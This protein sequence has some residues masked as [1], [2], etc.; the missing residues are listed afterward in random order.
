MR[1]IFAGSGQI[2]VPT[3]LALA[4]TREDEFLGVISQPDK[5]AGRSQRLQPCPVRAAVPDGVRVWQPRSIHDPEFV[6]ELEGLM[7]DL[8]VVFAYGQILKPSLLS[9]PRIGCINLHGSLLPR[10]RGAA[11]LQAPILNGDAETGWTVIWMDAGMDTGD[12]LLQT[13]EPILARETAGSLHDRMALRA[14]EVL[15]Q[16]LALIRRGEAPRVPQD[17]T[18]AT[19]VG[20]L[21]KEDGQVNWHQSAVQV[22]RHL[23]AMTPWP[24]AYTHFAVGSDWRMLRLLEAEPLEGGAGRPGEVIEAKGDRL[25]VACGQGSLRL[26]RLQPES[27]RPMSAADFINGYRISPGMCLGRPTATNGLSSAGD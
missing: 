20:R 7:P 13:R 22:D 27:G 18:Q 24:S 14:P 19:V 21:K 4:R 23:R 25:C 26:Q 16:A 5:P 17:H 8:M 15:A 11:C 10:Y 6:R 9:L 12:I 3:M 1:I 2:A